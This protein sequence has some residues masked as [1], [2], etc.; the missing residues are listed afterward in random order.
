MLLEKLILKIFKLFNKIQEIFLY[1]NVI[2]LKKKE[3]K[4][5]L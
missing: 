2:I 5:Y 1:N 3:L 4:K